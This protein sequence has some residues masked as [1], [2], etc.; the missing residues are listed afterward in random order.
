MVKRRKKVDSK[1]AKKIDAAV[2]KIFRYANYVY[3]YTNATLT[4]DIKKATY[5]GIG[6]E[7]TPRNLRTTI[8]SAS[9]NV[10]PYKDYLVITSKQNHRYI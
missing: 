8:T 3:P 9:F 1:E 7:I 10:L 5:F 4:N 6:I 2:Q